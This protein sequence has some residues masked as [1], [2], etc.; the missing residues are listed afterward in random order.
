[1]QGAHLG[2]EMHQH[3]F[4]G[5][6]AA[7]VVAVLVPVAGHGLLREGGE[8]LHHHPVGVSVCPAGWRKGPA[9]LY[10]GGSW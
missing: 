2:H 5:V 7:C 6:F 4:G 9:G 10:A 8:R 1:M 3:C